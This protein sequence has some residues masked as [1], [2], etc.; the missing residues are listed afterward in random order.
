MHESRGLGDVYKRQKYNHS[1]KTHKTTVK[2]A[3]GKY[4]YSGW[5][6][7]GKQAAASWE[8]AKTGNKAWADVK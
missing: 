7:K 1:K 2:G 3:G 5:V 8:K 6:G 4:S